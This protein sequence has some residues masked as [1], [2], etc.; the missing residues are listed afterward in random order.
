M[1]PINQKFPNVFIDKQGKRTVLYTINANPGVTVYTENLRRV[2]GKEY[3]E[4]DHTKSKLGAAIMKGISQI[5]FKEDSVVLYLGAAS[6]TTV[7]HISDML[8]KGFIFALDFAPRVVRDLMFLARERTNIA[9]LL[10]DASHPENYKNVVGE[11]DV[12]FQ[13]IAQSNQ[14]QIFL[15]NCD[16]YLKEGGFGLLAVKSR[17]VDVTKKPKDVYKQVRSDLEKVLTVVDYRELDPFE[18][19]HALF[20]VKKK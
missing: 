11:V 18:K 16:M 4:W 7:S 17:S 15:K 13:D 20:V 9:P 3:R 19:D 5:G 2:G 14:T 1:N 10:D 12:I 8:T 6:G